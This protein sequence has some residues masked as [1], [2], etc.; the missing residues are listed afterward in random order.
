MSD[1]RQVLA[2]LFSEHER[3][4]R[5]SVGC[6]ACLGLEFIH[7]GEHA[8]YVADMIAAEFLVAP[9]GMS[10]ASSTRGSTAPRMG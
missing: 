1:T 3:T 2:R 4:A 7:E 9:Q 6:R 8:E 10:S 5:I